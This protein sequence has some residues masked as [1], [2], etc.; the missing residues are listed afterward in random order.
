L[1]CYQTCVIRQDFVV[2]AIYRRDDDGRGWH[3][4]VL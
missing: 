2:V 1:R 4:V 3:R